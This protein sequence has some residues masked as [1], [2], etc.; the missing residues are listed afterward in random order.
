M[1]GPRARLQ[2][3]PISARG[4]LVEKEAR[5]GVADALPAVEKPQKKPSFFSL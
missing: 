3:E 4:S 2:I 5:R 1:R